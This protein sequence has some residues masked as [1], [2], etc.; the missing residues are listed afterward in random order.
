[1]SGNVYIFDFG[2]KIK[3]GFSTN[4]AKRQRTIELSSGVKARNV[5]SVN[6]GRTEEK[7]LHSW[8]DNRLEGEFFA[9]PFESAKEILNR[10]VSGEITAQRKCGEVSHTQCGTIKYDKLLKLLKE[11]GITSYTLKRDNI[12]GQAT[13]KKIKEGGDIDTRTI[14]KLC[15]LLDCQPGAIMEYVPDD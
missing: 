1:M 14:A 9:F 2:D 11:R 3:A 7:I 6:G 13:F 15:Q 5:Y 10:I 4:V 8:L 12:I